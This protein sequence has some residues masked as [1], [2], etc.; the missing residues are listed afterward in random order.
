MRRWNFHTP[1]SRF[2]VRTN[3]ALPLCAGSIVLRPRIDLRALRYHIGD[4]SAVTCA[5]SD[6][7]PVAL[8]GFVHECER[9]PVAFERVNCVAGNQ[10]AYDKRTRFSALRVVAPGAVFQPVMTGDDISRPI[11]YRKRDTA[12]KQ[13]DKPSFVQP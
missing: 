12:I 3:V 1:D 6:N 5:T 11:M 10:V 9:V 7:D 4:E 8:A 13:P 2:R